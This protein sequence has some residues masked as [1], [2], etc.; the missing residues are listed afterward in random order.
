MLCNRFSLIFS[1][2]FFL[3]NIIFD[4]F[5][6]I[7]PRLIFLVFVVVVVHSWVTFKAKHFC[8]LPSILS[9]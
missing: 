5:V 2:S 4:F 7:R 1:L 9:H 3:T 6:N 8:F